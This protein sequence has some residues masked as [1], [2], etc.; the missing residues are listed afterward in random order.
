MG[1]VPRREVGISV[2]FGPQL[3]SAARGKTEPQKQQQLGAALH[4]MFATVEIQEAVESFDGQGQHG[5]KSADQ[6][7]VGRMMTDMLKAVTALGVVDALVLDL[8]AL[9]AMRNRA[10]GLTVEEGN[11]SA[12]RF[13]PPCRPIC[14]GDRRTRARFPSRACPRDR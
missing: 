10:C 4:P 11:P 5:K 13:P 9:L 1:C 7:T 14:A 2:F 3:L 8:P 12:S 6:Q